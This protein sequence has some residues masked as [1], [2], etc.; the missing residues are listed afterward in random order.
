MNVP[1][2]RN[3][4]ADRLRA[5]TMGRRSKVISIGS[6][7]GGVGKTNLAVNLAIAL[8]RRG[9]Q[10]VLVDADLGLA[11]VDV[12]LGLNPPYTLD[13][14][15]RGE[16]TLREVLV[17]G[18]LEIQVLPG[19]SGLP[20]MAD[21]HPAK[22]RYLLQELEGL[23][24]STDILLIDAAPGIGRQV[25]SFLLASDEVLI[26]TTPEPTAVTD[27][28]ALI[29]LLYR[30]PS[31]PEVRLVVNMA[32]DLRDA[33]EVALKLGL[34]AR[35]YL[36]RWVGMAGAVPLDP[37]LPLAVRRQVPLVLSHPSSPASR[38]IAELAEVLLG[39]RPVK[40]TGWAARLGAPLAQEGGEAYPPA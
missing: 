33:Q 15:V 16:R 19:A 30:H 13:H 12:V 35:H 7:K 1:I 6:G 8:A 28:Y 21:L 38:A 10:V 3:D 27:A 4:Q 20:E 29:K 9:A 24:E 5:M 37:N 36:G 22:R 26:V 31:C 39:S 11:N 2:A 18:P 32:R 14:V 40:G 23:E 17:G 25:L 34:V